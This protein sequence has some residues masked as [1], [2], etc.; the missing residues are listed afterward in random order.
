[1]SGHPMPQGKAKGSGGASRPLAL[2]AVLHL[3][4]LIPLLAAIALIGP[5]ALAALPPVLLTG[6]CLAYGRLA[7]FFSGQRGAS[8]AAWMAEC[9]PFAAYACLQG[10]SLDL[11]SCLVLLA[12]MAAMAAG[13]VSLEDL[14]LP[15]YRGF[16][17][18]LA[19]CAVLVGLALSLASMVAAD[20][21]D[22]GRRLAI[23]AIAGT[24]GLLLAFVTRYAASRR[25]R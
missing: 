18:A 5:R 14:L 4:A 15:R 19:F 20:P 12:S 8:E 17:L 2:L 16:A 21:A 11:A 1:M 23:P 25:G 22:P 7:A 13:L 3:A 24:S 10:G 9:L 6:A